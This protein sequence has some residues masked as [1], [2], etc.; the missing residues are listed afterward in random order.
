[1]KY[2]YL[3]FDLDG[4][5]IDTREGVLKS[6][7]HALNHY[8]IRKDW[9]EL[10]PFFGPPLKYSFTKIYGLTDE[11]ADE[12]IRI[13]LDRYS[14]KGCI[15]SKVFDA[16]PDILVKLKS[17]GYILGVATSKYEGHAVESLES[18]GIA[19]YFEYITGATIDESISTKHEVIEESLKRFGITDNR[20]DV[21]MIGDMKYDVIGAKNAG[22]DSLGIYTGTAQAN[23]HEDAGATY[24]AY[25]FNEL[26]RMLTKELV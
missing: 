14:E 25:D 10:M 7:Q 23:E 3:L 15:E 19:Q 18:H 12:A 26:D 4:T 6:A 1:M 11:Q 24:V 9:T 5:L 21:L 13:Y 17:L 20:S 22:I 16:I 8:G 2:K